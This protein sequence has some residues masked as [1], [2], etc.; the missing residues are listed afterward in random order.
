MTLETELNELISEF[1][2][3]DFPD[4]KWIPEGYDMTQV[5]TATDENFHLLVHKLNN[6][7]RAVNAIS[8]VQ[9]RL[10]KVLTDNV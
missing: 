2:D 3:W 4:K 7:I 1:N 10:L 9:D 8:H 6:V 5:P